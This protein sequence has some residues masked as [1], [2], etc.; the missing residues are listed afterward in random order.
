[1]KVNKTHVIASIVTLL[2]I[3]GALLYLQYKKLM[4]YAIG[5]K[6]IRVNTVSKTK[7]SIDLFLNFLNK[8]KMPFN[9]VEQSYDIFINDSFVSTVKNYSETKI[10]ADGTSIIPVNLSFN[11]GVALG[12]LKENLIDIMLHPEKIKV[13]A[14][15]KMKVSFYGIRITIPY[16]FED[17]LKNMLSMSSK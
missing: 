12:V 7:I 5:I 15:I 14:K 8:S 1:M 11:P 9:I 3:S 10:K 4:D 6:S 2:S 13:T 16:L 17:S